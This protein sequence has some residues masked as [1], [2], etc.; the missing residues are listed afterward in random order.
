MSK[1][2]LTAALNEGLSLYQCAE[3]FNCCTLTIRNYIK[4]YELITRDKFY[5]RPGARIGRPPGFTY[6]EEQLQKMS[7]R[8][9]GKRNPFHGKKH[10][11]KTRIKMSRNHAD[12]SGDKNP[13]KQSLSDPVKRQEHVER[14]RKI[15][16]TRDAEYREAFGKKL[17]AALASSSNVTPH[18]VNHKSGFMETKKGGTVFYRSSWEKRTCEFLDSCDAVSSFRLEPFALKYIDSKGNERYTRIDFLVTTKSGHRAIFEVKPKALIDYG[19]NPFKIKGQKQYC[20]DN[21]IQ[22]AVLHED[23]LDKLNEIIIAIEQ[24]SLYVTE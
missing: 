9:R 2:D 10:S 14:C 13:F 16:A 21:S 15:W 17:S 23:N 6:T 11:L 5:S 20:K 24:E 18:Y 4:R 22:F 7:E 8:V 12:I 3:R 19:E 1:E